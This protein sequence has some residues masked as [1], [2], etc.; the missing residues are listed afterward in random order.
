MNR[1]SEAVELHL[2]RIDTR[3]GAISLEL[4]GI[5]KARDASEL[6]DC[7]MLATQSAQQRAIDNIARR[8]TKLEQARNQ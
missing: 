2:D 8:V 1:R 3:L 6:L 7:Q 5:S 4:S